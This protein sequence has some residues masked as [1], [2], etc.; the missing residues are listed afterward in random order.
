MT[1]LNLDEVFLSCSMQYDHRS[2]EVRQKTDPDSEVVPPG[3]KTPGKSPNLEGFNETVYILGSHRDGDTYKLNGFNQEE[4][5]GIPSHRD[6]P[7]TRN[8]M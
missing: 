8:Y 7:D 2:P 4:S 5:D 3:E 6:V 1:L